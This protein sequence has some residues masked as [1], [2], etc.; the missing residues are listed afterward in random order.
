MAVDKECLDHPTH[1]PNVDSSLRDLLQ[2]VHGE[3]LSELRLDK[4]DH[5]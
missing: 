2:C 3:E 1:S 5:S 4:S